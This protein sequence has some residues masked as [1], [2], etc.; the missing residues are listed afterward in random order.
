MK[1]KAKKLYENMVDFK[2]FAVL[3]LALGAFL[4]LGVI[5][6]SEKT[7]VAQYILI[8]VSLLFLVNSMILFNFSKKMRNKLLE[9]DEG[10]EYLMKK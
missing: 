7:E 2:Q 4:Y 5:I 1:N 6:P 8:C 3:F 10:Q 9:M